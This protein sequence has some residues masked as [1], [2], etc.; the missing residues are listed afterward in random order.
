MCRRTKDCWFTFSLPCLIVPWCW[1]FELPTCLS[2]TLPRA[3]GIGTPIASAAKWLHQIPNSL[4]IIS[5]Y[6]WYYYMLLLNVSKCAQIL[7]VYFQ[8]FPRHR[9]HQAWP[10][11]PEPSR[12]T[13]TLMTLPTLIQAYSSLF[14]HIQA[15]QHSN[16]CQ[17]LQPAMLL[18]FQTTTCW[19][20]F[21]RV[22]APNWRHLV[23]E[24][25]IKGLVFQNEWTWVAHYEHVFS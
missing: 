21:H 19:P 7:P 24:R 8:Y 10:K 23:A 4:H 20:C 2:F 13:K 3:L 16:R 12:H 9:R 17:K 22:H 11:R 18:G 1:C 15:S 25:L 14:K 5:G 6:I